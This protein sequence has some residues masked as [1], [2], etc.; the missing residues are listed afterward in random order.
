MSRFQDMM[1]PQPLATS[2]EKN[3]FEVPTPIQSKTIPFALQNKDVL[4][5]AQTGT[6]KTLA[7]L[8]PMISRLLQSPQESALIIVPTRELAQQVLKMAQ[9]ILQHC[10]LLHTALIIGGEP[11]PKQQSQLRKN[12]RI[13][14]G[15]PG[16]LIDH[17]ERGTM[18]TSISVLIIDEA[19][20]MFDMGFGIQLEEIMSYLP[21][22]RQT[23]M[24]SATLPDNVQKLVVKYLKDPERVRVGASMAPAQNIKHEVAYLAESEK[25]SKLLE[26]ISTREGSIILFVKTKDGA[27]KL[28]KKLIEENEQASAI[29]GNLRQHQREKILRG[30]RQGRSRIMVATDVAARGLDV[31]HIQH[32]INYDLPSA[33]EDYIHRIGRTARAGAEGCAL[34]FVTPRDRRKWSEI[35]NIMNPRQ[36]E[37]KSKFFSKGSSKGGS[38]FKSNRNSFKSRDEA[39]LLEPKRKGKFFSER[40]EFKEDR[41]SFHQEKGGESSFKPQKKRN[42]NPSS[43]HEETY[44]KKKSFSQRDGSHFDPR[45]K[46]ESYE[47]K[48]SFSQRD[49]SHFD[50]RRKEESYEKKKSFSQR[51]NSGFDPR[52]KEE[53]YEKK[54]SFSQRASSDFGPRKNEERGKSGFF[55][56]KSSVNK[57]ENFGRP[58]NAQKKFPRQK[59]AS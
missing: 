8:V 4:G 25:Y 5:V 22:E 57:T 47:K 35:Q 50:P 40:R 21:E 54:K 27:E 49:D 19:D 43:P 41:S 2:L 6:G 36:E 23:L 37:E 11:Y 10:P 1:L 3:K 39:S 38:S 45:R 20:R 51:D 29:H 15:T 14:V 7:F 26:E 44:E 46:E 48:K 52:K 58:Q 17:F 30:F 42:F 55:A 59:R 9:T 56:R 28:A 16:R 18:P 13:V 31:P 24:F 34:C 32:V 12:P 53:T 33:A